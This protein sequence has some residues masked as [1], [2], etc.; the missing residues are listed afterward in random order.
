MMDDQINAVTM[1]PSEAA[2]HR[3]IACLR[4]ENE[5]LSK[6]LRFYA[7]KSHVMG[8][9]KWETVSGEGENWLFPVGEDETG[10][11]EDGWV[12][13]ATLAGTLGVED[14]EGEDPPAYSGEPSSV[15]ELKAE[16]AMLADA[17]EALDRR[18]LEL[19][20]ALEA[21]PTPKIC[22]ESGF[23]LDD[24]YEDWHRITRAEA[25]RRE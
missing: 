1:R 10:G 14:W 25:L 22:R 9:E 3:E 7:A 17:A 8:C 24:D 11:L 19:R 2:L 16:C 13:R 23:A 5:R 15:A 20:A 21:A 4:A 18:T 12:A 6:G